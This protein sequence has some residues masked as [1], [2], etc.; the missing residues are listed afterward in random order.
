MNSKT[1]DVTIAKMKSIFARHGIL[2]IVVA[3]NMPFGSRAFQQFA[4]EWGFKVRSPN[5]SSIK[6]ARREKCAEDQKSF[7]KGSGERKR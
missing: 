5:L 2:N 4:K 1:A 3:D 7:K 6:W